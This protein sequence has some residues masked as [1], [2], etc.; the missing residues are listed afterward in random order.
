MR[1]ETRGGSCRGIVFDVPLLR[2]R[3]FAPQRSI[4]GG[5]AAAEPCG[6]EGVALV[7]ESGQWMIVG[8]RIRDREDLLLNGGT[9]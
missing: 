3:E 5:R 9:L 7:V 8:Q 1:T 2:K 6:G 4:R